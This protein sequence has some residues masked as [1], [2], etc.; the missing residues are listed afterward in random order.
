M[1]RDITLQ[2]P[3]RNGEAGYTLVAVI[4]AM[5]IIA[6]VFLSV[7]P[8]IKQQSQREREKEAI[9]RGEEVADAIVAFVQCNGGKLPRTMDDLKEGCSQGTRKR[10]IIRRSALVDPLTDDG[11]WKTV[12]PTSNEVLKF[13]RD[14][15]LYAG[16]T[17]KTTNQY[18]QKYGN[19]Q[20]TTVIDAGSDDAPGGED[21]SLGSTGDFI[22]VTSRSRRNSVITYYGIERHDR[23]VFTPL[24]R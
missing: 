12:T 13:G 10:Q 6:V 11:E 21:T 20:Y 23:W 1:G 17:P 9:A 2:P 8:N 3:M 15:T 7:V 22:G 4:A 5:S 18:L 14:V 16:F 24:F 19:R